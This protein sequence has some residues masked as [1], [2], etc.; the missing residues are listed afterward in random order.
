MKPDHS[1]GILLL[2][3]LIV[4][5]RPC[6]ECRAA[7]RQV[8]ADPQP[9]NEVCVAANPLH[10]DN[11]VLAFND[12]KTFDWSASYAYST[13]GGGIWS[14]GGPL[15]RGGL[16]GRPWCDPWLDF[17]SS[18]YLYCV[19]MSDRESSENQE[20]YEIFVSVA[21]P[22]GSGRVGPLGFGDP[23]IVDGGEQYNDRP[24]LAVD[25]SGSPFDGNVYVVWKHRPPEEE[26]G[27]CIYF[28][29]GRRAPGPATITWSP[30]QQIGP[31]GVTAG[32]HVDV[33]PTGQVYVTY[34]RGFTW[35][36]V[37]P[38]IAFYSSLDGGARFS[39]DIVAAE[40]TPV[41]RYVTPIEDPSDP[42]RDGWA[43]KS[44]SPTVA[45]SPSGTIFIA[46]ADQRHGDDDILLTRSTD[47]G[48]TWWA[49][50]IR[51]NDDPIGNGKDQ[52]EP[53]MAVNQVGTIDVFFYDRR[54]DPANELTLLYHARSKDN[55]LTFVNRTLSSAAT[56]PE[57]FLFDSVTSLGDYIGATHHGMWTYVAWGDGR[58]A[59]PGP[60]RDF[61]SDVYFDALSGVDLPPFAFFDLR[62][63]E[64]PRY[65]FPPELELPIEWQIRILAIDGFA[66]PVT[67]QVQGLPQGAQ[68]SFNPPAGVPPFETKLV[69]HIKEPVPGE[70]PITVR[71]VSGQRASTLPFRLKLTTGPFVFLSARM[72]DPRSTLLMNGAGFAPLTACEIYLDNIHLAS[73][74]TTQTGEFTAQI[75]V[76]AGA[77][78]GQH[79]VLA[80]DEKGTSAATVLTTPIGRVEEHDENPPYL[81][82]ESV[83]VDAQRNV[84]LIWNHLGKA[85]GY[86]V[87]ACSSLEQGDWSQLPGQWPILQNTWTDR[88][89][90]QARLR[91]YRVV[92]KPAQF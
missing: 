51:V 6:S 48:E 76:P 85:W 70:Y 50:P 19:A 77:P 2:G 91:V 46:W 29:K 9:Q 90:S 24:S 22:N 44:S 56:S 39:E 4:L 36:Y 21:A 37:G 16:E 54:S 20:N 89:F 8:Y 58:N 65:E 71:G 7:N 57:P 83:N 18:G 41:E 80:K 68:Y 79:T 45:I 35:G 84:T 53:A 61:N 13:D 75:A 3:C 14:Y 26:S 38:A 88:S 25:R 10:P 15:P 34:Y 78:K 27:T 33:G 59:S 5:S 87:E 28:R 23:Q 62:F 63:I 60:P 64:G 43:R 69:V 40:V 17:D 82:I 47:G 55:G 81:V 67:L 52:W 1:S 74:K 49:T 31:V 32:P 30:P 86:T 11:I 66:D 73:A 42:L 72:A 12:Y 92:A